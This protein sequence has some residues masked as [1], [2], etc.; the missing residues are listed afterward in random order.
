M[1]KSEIITSIILFCTMLIIFWEARIASMEYRAKNKP[2]VGIENV[3]ANFIPPEGDPRIGT[4]V[5]WNENSKAFFCERRRFDAQGLMIQVQIRNFGTDP[6]TNFW[7]DMELWI[8]NRSIK[9]IDPEFKNSMIMPGQ[10][11]IDFYNISKAD[12]LNTFINKE[13]VKI[14]YILKFGDLTTKKEPFQ[15]SAEVLVIDQNRILPRVANCVFVD[16]R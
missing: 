4:P 11:R 2:V 5:I 8:G 16:N 3:I 13:S 10:F 12:L 1:K 9:T 6:A 7:H 15:Y 14:K